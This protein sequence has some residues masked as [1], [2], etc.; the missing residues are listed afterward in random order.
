MPTLSYAFV[1][2]SGVAVFVSVFFLLAFG[3]AIETR[4]GSWRLACLW[5]IGSVAGAVGHVLWNSSQT[6]PAVGASGAV[7]AVV[8]ASFARNLRGHVPVVVPVVV[9]PIVLQLP[10]VAVV[11]AW[12]AM[13]VRPLQQLLALGECTPL[14]WSGLLP[15]FGVGILCAALLPGQR[16]VA[17]ASSTIRTDKRPTRRPSST[18][19][20]CR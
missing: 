15:A 18:R 10:A 3:T 8:A 2:G 20:R 1:P 7:S 14:S 17:K 13:Q 19:G 16:P 5:I 4:V 11:I 9:V 12:F 6:S